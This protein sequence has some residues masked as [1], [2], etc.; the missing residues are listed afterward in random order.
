MKLFHINILALV[1]CCLFEINNVWNFINYLVIAV[2]YDVDAGVIVSYLSA[3]IGWTLL[4]I[5]LIYLL[6]HS[7]RLDQILGNH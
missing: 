1:A 5:V 3:L 6:R 2:D 4:I 7:K